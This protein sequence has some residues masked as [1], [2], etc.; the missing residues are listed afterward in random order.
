MHRLVSAL[1]LGAIFLAPAQAAEPSQR[2]V[3]S[4]AFNPAVSLILDGRFASYDLDPEES[5][6]P[7]FLL[8]PETEPTAEGFGFHEAEL[9]ISANVDDLFYGNFVA[10]L[11]QHEGGTETEL[12]EAWIQTLTAPGGFT[13]KAGKFFSR[14]GYLNEKHPHAWDFSD[15]PLV[16]RAFL[17]N[18]LRDSGL[19]VRWVAPMPFFLEFGAEALR[20]DA[21]PAGGAADQGRGL[22]TLFAKL[23][24]DVGA[25]HA[26]Q[27]GV[28]R[29]RA[30]AE[31]RTGESHDPLAEPPLAFSGTSE[32]DIVDFVW[33]WAPDGNWKLRNLVFQAEWMRRKEAG[34]VETD[35]G[36]GPETG[37]YA[38]EQDGWYAQAVWQFMPRWR[39]GVR[40]DRLTADNIVN[41]LSGATVLDEDAHDPRR[42]SLM[43][44]YSHTEFSRIRVQWSRDES[45]EERD[46]QLIVQYIVSLGPHGAHQF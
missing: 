36:A 26:W 11:H 40:R 6:L 9:N 33:K 44:D 19:Q 42:T 1:V 20:G 27:I 25:S 30:E 23:G 35:F 16:Y 3:T 41:G 45:S 31:G 18:N 15:A 2:F 29:V 43:L 28:A 5:E 4:T 10:A 46:S 8:G 32:L 7:G 22:D 34:T 17:A 12:E 37:S 21:F 13:L 14:V 38:G 24:G 39:V